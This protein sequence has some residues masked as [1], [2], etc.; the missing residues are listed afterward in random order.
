MQTTRTTLECTRFLALPVA[1]P[2]DLLT[3]VAENGWGVLRDLHAPTMDDVRQAARE[4]S[5]E[6]KVWLRLFEPTADVVPML[7]N[8]DHRPWRGV[9]LSRGNWDLQEIEALKNAGIPCG[10]IIQERRDLDLARKH[11]TLPLL[12]RG[13]EAGGFNGP[14]ATLVLL[15]LLCRDAGE[16]FILEGGLGPKAAV[17]AV[18]AGAA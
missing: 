1:P 14:L 5:G 3:C 16:P 17:A 6:A 18:R 11:G 15:Q 8:L 2:A 9:Y 13:N 12:A 10:L 7:A 4:C